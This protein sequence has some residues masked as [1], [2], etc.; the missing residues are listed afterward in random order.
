[1]VALPLFIL[2]TLEMVFEQK[3]L[4]DELEVYFAVNVFTNPAR[5]SRN[6]ITTSLRV[7]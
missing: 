1:M 4:L 6:N 5:N 3:K 2:A 7:C